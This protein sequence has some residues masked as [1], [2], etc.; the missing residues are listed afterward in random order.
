MPLPLRLFLYSDRKQG[1]TTLL[2][3][4]CFPSAVPCFYL[5]LLLPL[6]L[7]SLCCKIVVAFLAVS[8][9]CGPLPGRETWLVSLEGLEE[10]DDLS[11]SDLVATGPC[12]GPWCR[13]KPFLDSV[14]PLRSA[15]HTSLGILAVHLGFCSQ[16][17]PVPCLFFLTDAND[18]LA[19]GSRDFRTPTCILG[20]A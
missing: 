12:A 19:L 15:Q 11:P 9:R 7:L 18:M 14:A 10:L 6:P 4:D 3:P 13:Q 20:F 17:R 8:P 1:A 16:A 5:H 2:F